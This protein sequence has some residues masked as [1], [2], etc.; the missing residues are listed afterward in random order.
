MQQPEVVR[1]DI[2]GAYF[3]QCQL[4]L[5]DKHHSFLTYQAVHQVRQLCDVLHTNCWVRSRTET[6]LFTVGTSLSPYT[7][8]MCSLMQPTLASIPSCLTFPLSYWC[9]LGPSSY[10]KVTV[11]VFIFLY[12]SVSSWLCLTFSGLCCLLF[13][14]IYYQLWKPRWSSRPWLHLSLRIISRTPASF[15]TLY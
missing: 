3:N 13:I 14:D 7:V 8:V 2:L 15:S 10:W 5:M 1:A 4:G 9:F 12:I 11:S 6:Q